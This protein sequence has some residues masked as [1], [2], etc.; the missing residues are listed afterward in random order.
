VALLQGNRAS[1]TALFQVRNAAF[2]E[3]ATD[4]QAVT[5]LRYF[6]EFE[7]EGELA[8]KY[9]AVE[10]DKSQKF[11]TFWTFRL[12][13]DDERSR[14]QAKSRLPF[15]GALTKLDYKPTNKKT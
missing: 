13:P 15:Q 10:H 12:P 1:V 6:A 4:Y 14:P 7:A 8:G 11:P 3:P 5:N 9:R 2:G